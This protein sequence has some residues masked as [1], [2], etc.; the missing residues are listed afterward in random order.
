MKL[1]EALR[2]VNVQV[3][4]D[5]QSFHVFLACG[6]T[7]LHLKTFLAAHLIRRVKNRPVLVE[8]GLY[9]SLAG[10]LE[11]VTSHSPDSMAVVIEWAD[12]DPRLGYRSSNGWRSGQTLDILKTVS[13]RLDQLST[14]IRA[15]AQRMTVAVA[16]PTLP[17][18]PCFRAPVAWG[19]TAAFAA[20]SETVPPETGTASLK[21]WPM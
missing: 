15:V 14:G 21:D 3:P 9:G 17:L 12:L 5:P 19:D 13:L 10:N 6:F 1:A 16:L 4:E 20:A 2:L 7:P 8:T 11:K 18:P